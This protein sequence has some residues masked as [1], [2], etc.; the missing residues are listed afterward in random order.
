MPSSSSDEAGDTAHHADGE[1]AR[2][3][4]ADR[5][6]RLGEQASHERLVSF[7]EESYPGVHIPLAAQEQEE[8]ER[9]DGSQRGDHLGHAKCYLPAGG[10]EVLEQPSQLLPEFVELV[11]EPLEEPTKPVI[12]SEP[13]DVFRRP[14]R[15][16]SR[17][18]NE[19]DKAIYLV[20]EHGQEDPHDQEQPHQYSQVGEPYS[21]GA[22]HEPVSALEP[23]YGRVEHRRKEKCDDKPAHEGAY[24][25]EQ[26]ERA[27]N[28]GCGEQ[29]EGDRA[30]HL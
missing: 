14:L 27:K 8:G 24:L 25:P 5:P 28:Y 10:Q 18:G 22:L 11:A 20:G 30:Y 2:D 1:V 9:K 3:V 12:L 15:S 29:G 23:V 6:R 7:W 4:A 19:L 21:E 26:E 16:V 13:L 17:G